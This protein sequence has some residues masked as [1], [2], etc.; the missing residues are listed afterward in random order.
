MFG[1]IEEDVLK[2][3]VQNKLENEHI[4]YLKTSKLSEDSL[5]FYL[6]KFYLNSKNWTEFYEE[7]KMGEQVIVHDTNLL[8][9][10]TV[11]ILGLKDSIR[12]V[13]FEEV[14]GKYKYL[15]FYD[16]LYS[17]VCSN[18]VAFLE[19]PESLQRSYLKYKKAK[20]K[21]P[22][23]AAS[24]STIIPGLGGVYLGNYRTG[25]FSLFTMSIFGFQTI[26]SYKIK[27]PEHI[28]TIAN[29]GFFTGYYVA[30]IVG[31]FRDAKQK[32]IEYRNQFLIDASTYY[33]SHIGRS[34]Y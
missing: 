3:F 27:G 10:A 14:V 7:Y 22:I 32:K 25:L 20:R 13:W 21:S 31:S 9:I 4:T 29:A 2:H 19:L 12:N 16:S 24:L 8:E 11:Q 15:S 28:L 17:F 5:H 33:R 6:A 18:E 23:L 34:L 1:Q 26:E 30:N